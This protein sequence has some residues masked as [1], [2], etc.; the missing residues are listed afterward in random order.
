MVDCH[1]EREENMFESLVVA[2]RFAMI[3]YREVSKL[4][5]ILCS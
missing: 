2:S 5:N 1:K 3:L 4:F